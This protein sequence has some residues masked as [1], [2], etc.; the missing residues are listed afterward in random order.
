MNSTSY[1]RRSCR[2]SG[3]CRKAETPGREGGDCPPG[4][5]P[6]ISFAN[7]GLPYYLSGTVASMESLLVLVMSTGTAPAPAAKDDQTII[8]FS[9]N[10][11]KVMAAFIIANGAAEDASSNL[12]I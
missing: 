11:D 4:K 3:V 1:H 9:E 7:C 2:V 5:R 12:F 8:V 6:Y 10:L